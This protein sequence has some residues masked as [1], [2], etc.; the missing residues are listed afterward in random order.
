MKNIVFSFFLFLTTLLTAQVVTTSPSLPTINDAILIT[1]NATGTPLQGYTGDVYSHT[2]VTVDGVKWQNVI[3]TWGNNTT[4]PKLTRTGTDTYTLS[5][6]SN[7]YSYYNVISTKIISE[8]NFVFRAS[9][10]S[11]QSSDIFTTIYP[12]ATLNVSFTNPQNNAV[13]NLNET[14]TI[15]AESTINAALEL[16]INGSSIQT[17]TNTKSISKSYTFNVTGNHSLK[18]TAN[19]GN[20]TKEQTINIYVKTPTITA[21]KPVGLKYGL[22]KNPDNSVTFL[23]KAPFK[24][25]IFLLGDFNDWSLN[26]NYQMKKDGED[27]WITLSNLDINTEY[28]YQY[29]ID[30]TTKVA[31]PYSEKILDP[32][33]DQYIKTGNYPNLKPFPSNKT[34]GYV[35]TFK[36]NED[37]Y[38]WQIS[39]F[40]KPT[41]DN[42]IIY[43]LF[44]RDFT[45]T[46]S[47]KEVITK[48]DYLKNLGI[49]A[50][51]LM[52]INEFEGADSWGYNPALYM[53]LD[54]SYGTKNDFKRLVD[55]CHKRGIAV[56]A[57]VVFNHSYGQSPL[58]QM[59]FN[60]VTNKPAANN[61][62]YNQNHNFVDNT[63]AQWGYDFNHESAYTKAFFK[64]VLNYWMTEYKIDGFRFDFTKGMTNTQFTGIDNWGSAYDASRISI[65]KEYA[66]HVWSFNP[67]NKPFVIFEHL[68]DNLE[69]KE[70]ADFGIMMWGNMNY[71]YSQN[72][73]GYTT[74]TD[75][76]TISYKTRNWNNP[77]LVGYMESHDEERMMYRN[78]NFGNATSNPPYNVKDLK[79]ALS[80]QELAGLFFLTIPGPK[81]IWQFGEL[82]YDYSINTCTDGTVN[83]SCRLARKPIKWDYFSDANRK[84][85]YTTWATLNA[86]RKQQPVFNTTDYTL[87]V[88][89][90]VKSIQLRH[91]SMDVVILGNFDITIKSINPNFTKTGTWYEYFTGEVRSVTNQT[92]TIELKPGEYR[93]YSSVKLTDPF[94]GT[95]SDDSDGDGVNDVL[96][97]CPNT[98]IG[99]PVNETGC[100]LFSL[101]S[102][103]F[104]LEVTQPTC[105]NKNNGQLKITASENHNY[106]ATVNG[107]DYAFTS[108]T[109]IQNL[110]PN[111][112][113]VC[114]KIPAQNNYTQ[115]FE[116][117]ITNPPGLSSRTSVDTKGNRAV[118]AI[119]ID[120]GTPPF[121]INLN[122]KTQEITNETTANI[123][124][125][126]GDLIEVKSS[127]ACEGVIQNKI[128]LLS[129]ITVYP[130]PTS[131]F[132]EI[133]IPSYVTENEVKIKIYNYQGKLVLADDFSIIENQIKIS[134]NNFAN[135]LYVMYVQIDKPITFKII[136]K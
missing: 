108:T 4:Q 126:N 100:P 104:R 17:A 128:N 98:M 36:I 22:N 74:G 44:V 86:F 19:D 113:T 122:G 91:T 135:G 120:S 28:A 73:L 26:A 49:N 6:S 1:F 79:T 64:D 84:H 116:V 23:L 117:T 55:E 29:Y 96:D 11:P 80:R 59:Y 101:A 97:L 88:G 42:L 72:S 67:T 94:G 105:I 2:G 75:I 107:T 70:L 78:L 35:S 38:N 51:E 131:D 48:L 76:S 63:N 123:L 7:V 40:I 127:I 114:I 16:F 54:K 60:S 50:I 56:L 61:P 39:N 109:T 69:E 47:F 65:L 15:S 32:W 24:N 5:I 119:S 112:Y 110:A 130:N 41:Q 115:C 58:L 95:A 99:T 93:L 34:T 129:N 102:T 12:A 25:D 14:L 118:A 71:S 33:T 20:T 13:L 106:I 52:P 57:D 121:T 111:T 92:A 30:Y 10:G 21:T 8:L 90:L 77:N 81:M 46:D 132:I 136:K 133:F 82:G 3:G 62:W 37:I 83:N 43:E 103:N 89:S 134:L 124:V 31:D 45:E 66:S 125:S 18:V 87:N 68:S 53:A 85:L 9:S 27:F